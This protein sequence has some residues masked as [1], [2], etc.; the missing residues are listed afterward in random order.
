MRKLVNSDSTRQLWAAVS[1]SYSFRFGWFLVLNSNSR[2]QLHVEKRI[3]KF[4][5]DLSLHMWVTSWTVN[6]SV[7]IKLVFFQHAIFPVLMSSTSPLRA[8]TTTTTQLRPST[9]PP[10][11]HL[12]PHQ[13][14][15]RYASWIISFDHHQY[16]PSPP[17]SPYLEIFC[18]HS[19]RRLSDVATLHHHRRHIRPT[20]DEL[21]PST[22]PPH[23][24]LPPGTRI[25][26]WEPLDKEKRH[27]LLALFITWGLSK[28]DSIEWL[29]KP[30]FPL[31]FV[32]NVYM[33]SYFATLNCFLSMC[34]WFNCVWYNWNP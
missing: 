17:S 9:S 34:E 29:N 22:W 26:Q 1:R 30:S 14:D 12:Q 23:H 10:H 13:V 33:D 28:S 27:D 7:L 4:G 19:C 25:K 5:L 11:H 2:Y 31:I 3:T 32:P 21:R 24:R 6:Q 20:Q 8:T 18:V 15:R 16:P